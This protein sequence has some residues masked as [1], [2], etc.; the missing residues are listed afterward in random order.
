[1]TSP[2]A[3][4]TFTWL[5]HHH[6][7]PCLFSYRKTETVSIQHSLPSPPPAPSPTIPPYESACSAAKLSRFSRV[8]LCATPKTAAH[9]APPSLGF[10]RQEHWSGLPFPS[11]SALGT[12]YEWIIHDL[13][14]RDWHVHPCPSMLSPV[15]GLPSLSRLGHCHH[16]NLACLLIPSPTGGSD[17]KES[18]CNVGD[19]GSIPGFGRSPGGGNGNPF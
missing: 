14:F 15:S 2:V 4:G 1:M 6:H 7:L 8:R 11:Q 16:M 12:S 17:G 18:A 9:Q 5:C 19:L 10:S 3:L 13:S